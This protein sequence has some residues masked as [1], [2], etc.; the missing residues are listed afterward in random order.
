MRTIPLGRGGPA[1]PLNTEGV[2]QARE[3]LVTGRLSEL[4]PHWIPLDI[5]DSWQRCLEAKLDPRFPPSLEPISAKQLRELR[6]ASARIYEIARMEVRNLYSQIAGSHF[7]VAFATRDATILEVMADPSFY[8]SAQDAGIVLGSQWQES[9]RGTNALGCAAETL[10]PAA[11]HGVEHFFTGNG[12]LTCVASPVLDHEDHLVGVIDA[13]SDCHSRQMHTVALIRMSALHI[14]AELFRDTFRTNAI[15]QFHNRQEFVHTLDAGLIAFSPEGTIVASNRQARFFLQDLP[16]GPGQSFDAVFRTSYQ[17]FV[18]QA[19]INDSGQITDRRGSTYYFLTSNLGLPNKVLAGINLPRKNVTSGSQI[20]IQPNFVCAD[21][22][23]RQAM[24]VAEQATQRRVPILIRG[25]TGTGKE[26]LARHVHAVSGRAGKF[27]AVNCTALP[28]NLIEAEFFGYQDGAFTGGRRGGARGLILEADQGTLF[29][30]EIGDMPM[31]L[32]AKL[33]RF[34]DQWTVRAVGSTSEEVVNVQIVSATNS[35]LE[36]AVEQRQ[37]RSDLLYRLRGVEVT[38]PPLRERSDFAE[39]VQALL[40]ELGPAWAISDDAIELIRQR[41]WPGN[42]RELKNALLRMVLVASS[43]V[44]LPCNVSRV[45]SLVGADPDTKPAPLP[46]GN[47]KKSRADRI[48]ETYRSCNE[49]VIRTARELGVSRHTVYRELRRM[50][51]EKRKGK[52]L[53]SERKNPLH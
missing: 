8:Q 7:V 40:A 9:V 47:L 15:L 20:L 31:P 36:Q 44:L 16:V 38:L 5:R 22:A 18:A 53:R 34:L 2:T 26:L 10:M 35:S 28:E 11:I 45:L 12:D 37:F 52:K 25:E 14:E 32:Q 46:P 29:L 33:L 21:P 42:F 27:V 50:G 49:N 51:I 13:S 39:I 17:R 41:R 30:D 24:G 43:S 4:E 3:C 1:L 6:A 23:V 48:V 19:R